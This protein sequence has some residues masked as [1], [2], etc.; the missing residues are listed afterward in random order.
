M[1]KRPSIGKPRGSKEDNIWVPLKGDKYTY[2][3]R[4]IY[5]HIGLR[6]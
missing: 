6:V 3:Y 1:F 5:G 2:I 4:I